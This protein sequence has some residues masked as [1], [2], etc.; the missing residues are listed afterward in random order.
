M[1]LIF[2]LFAAALA[3]PAQDKAQIERGRYLVEDVGACKFCHTP[4]T[5]SG[6]FDMSKHL[7][8]AVLDIMPLGAPP[9][10]WHK[11]SPDLT[12]TSR[13]WSRWG[14]GALLKYLETGL[15]PKGTAAGPPMPVYKYSKADAEAVLAYL[16]TLK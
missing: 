16:K 14:E 1:R 4:K 15:T 7:K 2:F 10:D 5:E 13:L 9:K 11:T 3:L 6:E 12:P 8:C